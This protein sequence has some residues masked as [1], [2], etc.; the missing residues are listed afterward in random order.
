MTERSFRQKRTPGAHRFMCLAA[1]IT[2]YG[3]VKMAAAETRRPNHNGGS[4]AS[5]ASGTATFRR[6]W[7]WWTRLCRAISRDA[8]AR[9]HDVSGNERSG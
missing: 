1:Q 9:D 5:G 3:V 4:R 2:R 8:A 6:G 7:S